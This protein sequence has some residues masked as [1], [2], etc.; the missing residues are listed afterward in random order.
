MNFQPWPPPALPPPS[1]AL[2]EVHSGQVHL[3]T[4]GSPQLSDTGYS[5]ASAGASRQHLLLSPFWVAET[6]FQEGVF[7]SPGAPLLHS[8]LVHR[9]KAPVY[10]HC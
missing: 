3:R 9:E 10:H 7:E 4:Q 2:R 5:I 8:G 6:Q 1:S